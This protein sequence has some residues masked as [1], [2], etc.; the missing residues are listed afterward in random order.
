MPSRIRRSGFTLVELLVVIAIIG[1]LVA[2]LLP[3]V[4]AAREAARRMQCGNN[5]KQIGL[6]LHN[7]HDAYNIFPSGWIQQV[8]AVDFAEAWA[9]SALALPF[10]EQGPL[11]DQLGVT[12]VS[13]E[14]GFATGGVPYFNLTRTPIKMFMCPSDSGYN[15]TGLIHNNRNFNNGLGVLAAGHATPVLVAVSNY[16]GAAGHRDPNT[17]APAANGPPPNTG[18]F[19]GN[20]GVRLAHVI[21]GTSN[22][23]AV[24]E[25]DTLNCR[26]GTWVGVRRPTGGGT[27]GWSVVVGQSQPKV[28]EPTSVIPWDTGRT[29]CGG[30]FSS[31][32]PGGAQFVLCD[33]SVRFVSETI[34]HFWF[35]TT[36]AGTVNDSKDASNGVYQRLMTR[37]DKLPI[38]DY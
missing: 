2:L 37:D 3:A 6:G 1:I 24:G 23:F 31:L 33:G 19:Y 20:S 26:S 36:A 14:R 35:G 18:V 12:K 5:L 22:T 17:A 9:W 13:L 15:G 32:H 10:V 25:R 28:N 4:Q 34:N 11:H 7:Y 27:Q 38:G 8:P 30:G 16:M 29:G 21:D